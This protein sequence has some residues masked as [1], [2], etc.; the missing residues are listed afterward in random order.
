MCISIVRKTIRIDA[1]FEN[2]PGLLQLANDRVNVM[3]LEYDGSE[4]EK[5]W[6]KL[7]HS[8]QA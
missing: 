2:V 7:F 3:D 5:P 8:E 6:E 4:L 1:S